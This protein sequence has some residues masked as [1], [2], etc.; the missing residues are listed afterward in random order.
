MNWGNVRILS[1]GLKDLS[2]GLWFYCAGGGG[3]VR[4]V[5]K[6]QPFWGKFCRVLL[7]RE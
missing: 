6:L 7:F 3:L 2:D 5:R 1:A 4:K